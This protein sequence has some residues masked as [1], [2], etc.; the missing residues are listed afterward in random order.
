MNR[1]RIFYV[2][3]ATLG[4]MCFFSCIKDEPEIKDVNFSASPEWGV[5]LAQV[6]LSAERVI[7]N[8]D[9]EGMLLTGEDGLISV[10][11]SD[12]LDP[13]DVNDFL[14]LPDQSFDTDI[15][16]GI[17]EFEELTAEGSLTI[18]ET[19]TFQYPTQEGDR[20]DSVRFESGEFH[21]RVVSGLNVQVSGTLS[22]LD[23]ATQTPRYSYSF[24]DA[25]P[26]VLIDETGAM[27]NVLLTFGNQM[28]SENSFVVEYDLELTYN[29][30]GANGGIGINFDFIDLTIRAVGGYIAPRTIALEDEGLFVTMFNDL[31]G[32]QVRIEDPRINFFFDNGFGLGSQIR[33]GGI[34]GTNTSGE[35]LTVLGENIAELPIIQPAPVPGESVITEVMID[36]DLMTP[37]VTDFLA[38]Y[39]NF[40]TGQFALEINPDDDQSSFLSRDAQLRLSYEAEIPVY[41][42]ISDFSISD[43]TAIDLTDVLEETDEA[44][45]IKELE[46]RVIIDNGLPV[47]A[48][49]QM[50]FTDSLFQPVDSLFSNFTNIFESAPLELTVP[51]I[52]PDYGRAIGTTRN[53]VVIPVERERVEALDEVTHIVFRVTGHTTSN[54]EH[55]IRLFAQDFFNVHVAARVKLEINE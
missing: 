10:I 45:E 47:T 36:N 8:F 26:P 46:V 40:V 15:P 54:G 17:A 55:P 50:L 7:D 33:I 29:G 6:S 9:E 51:D 25:Q 2:L 3:S 18:N 44:E 28:G 11:Y 12:T 38:F 48:G 35:V 52:H 30:E 31:S 21:L 20:L 32:A 42:S 41:G 37:S 22:I 16:L 4:C 39:P 14:V 13:V 19:R 27:E 49:L 1:P 24:Q 53:T 5:A 34:S 43:T 23:P